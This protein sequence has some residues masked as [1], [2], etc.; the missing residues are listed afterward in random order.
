MA[1]QQI[2]LDC[3]S[4]KKPRSAKAAHFS[5]AN[6]VSFFIH[7]CLSLF[8][9]VTCQ[10]WGG[11]NHHFKT[12]TSL[13]LRWQLHIYRGIVWYRPWE[14]A[15]INAAS[16]PEVRPRDDHHDNAEPLLPAVRVFHF[17]CVPV[18][19]KHSNRYCHSVKCAVLLNVPLVLSSDLSDKG[20]IIIDCY[21]NTEFF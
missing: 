17:K 18:F 2:G 13:K 8:L 15:G 10:W 5:N 12:K 6:G 1:V 3:K 16:L 7:F 19:P 21:L 9:S 4:S 20:M 14:R 11:A